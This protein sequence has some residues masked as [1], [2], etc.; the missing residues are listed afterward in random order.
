MRPLVLVFTI[1]VV[2]VSI[3]AAGRSPDQQS[4]ASHSEGGEDGDRD[5]YGYVMQVAIAAKGTGL[6]VI[7]VRNADASHAQ[8]ETIPICGKHAAELK[9]TVGHWTELVYSRNLNNSD[10]GFCRKLVTAHIVE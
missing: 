1:S 10:R 5:V 6:T 8:W 3:A 7:A 2:L 9:A 4:P